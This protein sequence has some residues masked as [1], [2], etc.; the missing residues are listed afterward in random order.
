MK[1][2]GQGEQSA[3]ELAFLEKFSYLFSAWLPQR[4]QEF[5]SEVSFRRVEAGTTLLRQGQSCAHLPFVVSGSVRVYKLAENGREITLYRVESGMSC[6][7]SAGCLA[8]LPSFPAM[9]VTESDS[10]I[11]FFSGPL[12]K[13]LLDESPAFR[14]FLLNQFS[15]RMAGVMELVEEV[16]FR[17]MDRRLKDWLIQERSAGHRV[18]ATHQEIADHL[19]TSREVVSRILKDWESRGALELSRGEISLLSSFDSLP[20]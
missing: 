20:M 19:G 18:L 4:V 14:D 2:K 5:L 16:A 17:H 8:S 1:G 15:E 3:E 13:R 10:L 11:A 12:V 6:I 9:V 7:L